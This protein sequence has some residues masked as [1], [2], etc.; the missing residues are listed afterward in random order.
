MVGNGDQSGIE[1]WCDFFLYTF[2][3]ED[4]HRYGSPNCEVAG[5]LGALMGAYHLLSINGGMGKLISGIGGAPG[6][7]ALVIGAGIVGEAATEVLTA[8][9]AQVTVMDINTWNLK[10]IEA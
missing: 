1:G 8:L 10:T 4:S 3:A 5:K 7:K 2:T 6:A 9:G